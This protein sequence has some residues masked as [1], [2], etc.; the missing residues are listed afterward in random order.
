MLCRDCVRGVLARRAWIGR[1]VKCPHCGGI[2]RVP[3]P[4]QDGRTPRGLAPIV[5]G[6]HFNFACGRCESLL[7]ANTGLCGRAG[8]C[9]TCGARFIVPHLDSR[10]G[11]PE[12]PAV[13]EEDGEPPMPVHAYGA[14]G[15]SAPQIVRR[16]DGTSAIECPRCGRQNPVDADA[17]GD[18]STP[19]TMAATPTA[20][21][22]EAGTRALGALV[23]GL[24]SLA[25]LRHGFFALAGIG[26]IVLGWN[27]IQRSRSRKPAA[28]VVAIVLGVLAFPLATIGKLAGFW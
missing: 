10:T 26:A 7:E 28:A 8:R 9:P 22:H 5:G 15:A 20:Y 27:A 19:F 11:L 18:C 13:V 2:M 25:A 21:S 23:L 4:A 24:V 1:E 14:S 17:C 12:G 16:P 6:Q 3:E